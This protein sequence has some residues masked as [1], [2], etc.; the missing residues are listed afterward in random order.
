MRCIAIDVLLQQKFK[1]FES[2]KTIEKGLNDAYKKAGHNAYFGNG[3]KAGVEF[4]E[5]FIPI[6]EEL[7][8]VGEPVLCMRIEGGMGGFKEIAPQV[9]M[10]R[11]NGKFNCEFDWVSVTH[12]RP[13]NHK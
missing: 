11:P 5:R 3:F 13:I 7:P 6:D 4:A 12:W 2:M 1:T 9:G 8:E 10:M